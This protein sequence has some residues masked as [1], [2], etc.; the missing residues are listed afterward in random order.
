MEKFKFK[1]KPEL[2]IEESSLQRSGAARGAESS[3]PPHCPIGGSTLTSG[4]CDVHT[5]SEPG[6]CTYFGIDWTITVGCIA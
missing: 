6:E 1:N 2:K 4:K 5:V 3:I